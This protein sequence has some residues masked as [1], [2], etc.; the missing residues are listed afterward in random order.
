MAAAIPAALILACLAMNG[1]VAPFR[2]AMTL[3]LFAL[4]ILAVPR[5]F[6]AHKQW[7]LRLE[8]W[9]CE[10]DSIVGV[11][12]ISAALILKPKRGALNYARKVTALRDEEPHHLWIAI[13]LLCRLC[14]CQT[15]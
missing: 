11:L 8:L 10:G 6:G 9:T 14:R 5:F 2:S 4:L 7:S 3:L 13:W 15:E 1:I 12:S